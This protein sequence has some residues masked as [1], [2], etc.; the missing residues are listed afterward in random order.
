M[1]TGGGGVGGQEPAEGY[2]HT[3]VI[4]RHG[5]VLREGGEMTLK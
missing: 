2:P 1:E 4:Y 5:A 3:A